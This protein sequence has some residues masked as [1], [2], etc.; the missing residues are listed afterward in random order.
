MASLARLRLLTPATP[1]P[2]QSPLTFPDLAGRIVE[3]VGT[4]PSARTSWLA[5]LVAQTQR[6]GENVAWILPA[7]ASALPYPPD[8]AAVGIDLAR[9]VVVRVPGKAAVG[10]AK[11]ADVLLRS[12]GFGLCALDVPEITMTDA[13]L[14]RLLGLCQKHGA[15]LVVLGGGGRDQGLGSLVSLRLAVRRARDTLQVEVLKD[16]RRGPG[17]GAAEHWRLPEGVETPSGSFGSLRGCETTGRGP[18]FGPADKPNPL[19]ST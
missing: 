4:A 10:L 8:L 13:M 16:K 5:G 12:G 15:A 19:D 1:A 11:A 14:G 17:R 3:L 6:L 9:L 2:D 18:R 7:D